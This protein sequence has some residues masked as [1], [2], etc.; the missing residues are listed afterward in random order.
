MA[1]VYAF[2]GEPRHVPFTGI[3]VMS[4]EHGVTPKKCC[5]NRCLAHAMGT[6]PDPGRRQEPWIRDLVQE[7][8]LHMMG[9]LHAFT[10]RHP[11][12]APYAYL[13]VA[14]LNRIR[15]EAR[16]IARRPVSVGRC[17]STCTRR[18]DPAQRAIG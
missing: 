13:R 2:S 6:R 12:I 8:A 10:P 5:I 17:P 16:R 14:A 3:A 18:R 9:K 1:P 15:D 4:Q 11:G 7:T